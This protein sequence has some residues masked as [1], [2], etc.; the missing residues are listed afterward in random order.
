MG[1]IHIGCLRMSVERNRRRLGLIVGCGIAVAGIAYWYMNRDRE[2]RRKHD[3]DDQGVSN[4]STGGE[5]VRVEHPNSESVA[6]SSS[7]AAALLDEM[8]SPAA[9]LNPL[10]VSNAAT[11]LVK[12]LKGCTFQPT[13]PPSTSSALHTLF[14]YTPSHSP[15]T[16]KTLHVHVPRHPNSL[17]FS[18]QEK[19][20]GLQD[21]LRVSGVTLVDAERDRYRL[22]LDI[23][24]DLCSVLERDSHD[25]TQVLDLM[26]QL[27]E[28]GDPPDL[29]VV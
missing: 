27:Q 5:W 11:P 6:Q 1:A 28:T 4:R 24:T 14:L 22:Q 9:L 15:F 29:H 10:K 20:R 23:I 26:K 25:T 21:F 3:D 19:K 2:R 18:M 13:A 8:F 17:H 16:R 7:Q 12:F